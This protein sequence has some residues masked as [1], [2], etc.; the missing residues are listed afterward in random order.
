[1]VKRPGIG[2]DRMYREMVSLGHRPPTIRQE[3]GPQVRTRLAGGPPLP[4][5]IASLAAVV[6]TV[7]QRDLRG[8]REAVPPGVALGLYVLLRD[9]FL[10]AAM[11][12]SLLQVPTDEAEE[13]LNVLVNCTVDAEPLMRATA[14]APWLPAQGIV[15]P[16]Y[17]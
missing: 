13:A 14:S 4:T 16:S 9:G 5:V 3:P 7:R 17:R 6:P 8:E 2:V 15:K 12:A 11:L 10:T 1:M